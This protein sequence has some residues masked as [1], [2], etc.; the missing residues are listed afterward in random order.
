MCAWGGGGVLYITDYTGTECRFC[1]KLVPS[2]RLPYAKM[3]KM[4]STERIAIESAGRVPKTGSAS[5]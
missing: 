5:R 2:S 1:S 3:S 4:L